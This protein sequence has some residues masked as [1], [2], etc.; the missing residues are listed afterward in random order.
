MCSAFCIA[1]TSDCSYE[2]ARVAALAAAEA[3]KLHDNESPTFNSKRAACSIA[4]ATG[5]FAPVPLALKRQSTPE[6]IKSAQGIKWKTMMRLG[7]PMRACSDRQWRERQLLIEQRVIRL[8]RT[9]TKPRSVSVS[10]PVLSSCC[11]PR[12]NRLSN[13]HTGFGEAHQMVLRDKTSTR[14]MEA[15]H[16]VLAEHEQRWE[17]EEAGEEASDEE[18]QAD[19]A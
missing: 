8:R 17:E 9:T 2:D 1:L 13:A 15:M 3:N 12:A 4:L 7:K 10:V 16:A 18:M 19:Q 5:S 14:E 6:E 11:Y